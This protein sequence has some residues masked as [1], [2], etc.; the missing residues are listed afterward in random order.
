MAVLGGLCFCHLNDISSHKRRNMM[1]FVK[2]SDFL[3]SE[4]RLMEQV[5]VNTDF[6]TAER[7]PMPET[8]LTSSDLR[9]KFTVRP[10]EHCQRRLFTIYCVTFT[11]VLR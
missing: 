5:F 2:E 1:G 7:T 10:D 3:T 9:V 8:D 4:R 6:A 11:G